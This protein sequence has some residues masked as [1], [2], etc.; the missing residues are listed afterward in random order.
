MITSWNGTSPRSSRPEKIIR[1]SQ[2]RMIS[3]EAVLTSPG[4]KARSSDAPLSQ[5][6]ERRLLQLVHRAPP[7]ERDQRLDP[8]LAALA[9][10][11]RVPVRLP[12]HELPV[13]AQPREDPLLRLVLRQAGEVARLGAHPSV[14]A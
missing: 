9:A 6:L 4:W 12:A 3:R 14:G 5:R 7:L 1:F 2:R 10:R 8:R 11:D 13:L